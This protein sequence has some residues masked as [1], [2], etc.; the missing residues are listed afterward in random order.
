MNLIRTR[1]ILRTAVIGSALLF[2]LNGGTAFASI[3]VDGTNDT[4]GPY[5]ENENEWNVENDFDLDIDNDADVDNDWN[6]EVN[7]GYN[8]LECNTVI[9]DISTGDISGMIEVSN[10]LNGGTVGLGDEILSLGD[11]DFDF[12]NSLTGPNSENENEANIDSNV[13]VDINND[14]DLDNRLDVYL[15]TGRN[16][17]ENNTQVGDVKT[18]NIDLETRT[19]NTVNE[20]AGSIDLGELE[21]MDIDG[22]F[23]NDTTGPNSQNS[24]ELNLDSNVDID[25]NNDAD[26]DNDTNITA[27]TGDN[28]VGNNT[29]VGN[30]STGD[31]DLSLHTTNIAN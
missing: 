18:G 30:V 19:I 12:E 2:A 23:T 6:I 17:I 25:I 27:N 1:N 4:T 21:G 14:A 24:N 11:I 7:T 13:N 31:I 29:V 3:S 8:N 26:I 9:E 5:S 20:N 16:D 10:T 22:D 28:N 15:N